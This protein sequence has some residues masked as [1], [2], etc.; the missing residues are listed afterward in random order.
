ME[1]VRCHTGLSLLLMPFVF[2]CPSEAWHIVDV[3]QR[4]TEVFSC[5]H[6]CDINIIIQVVSP[7]LN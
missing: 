4:T 1:S 2:N 3:Y 5:N 7:Y 6:F